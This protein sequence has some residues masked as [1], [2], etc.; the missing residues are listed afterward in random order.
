MWHKKVTKKKNKVDVLRRKLADLD[1]REGRD[2][3]TVNNELRAVDTE[4]EALRQKRR[5]LESMIKGSVYMKEVEHT[6]EAEKKYLEDV[7]CIYLS[8][9]KVRVLNDEIRAIKSRYRDIERA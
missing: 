9:F 3:I 8:N 7:S 4:C 2:M 1:Q 6:K 5:Y